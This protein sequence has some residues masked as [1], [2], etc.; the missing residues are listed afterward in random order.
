MILDYASMDLE[1]IT[2]MHDKNKTRMQTCKD[3]KLEHFV[4]EEGSF[5]KEVTVHT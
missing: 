3:I 5:T 1:Y 4:P 2:A